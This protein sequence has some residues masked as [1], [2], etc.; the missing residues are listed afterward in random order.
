MGQPDLQLG[1]PKT[2]RVATIMAKWAKQTKACSV[3]DGHIL[4]F[5]DPI[6]FLFK[7]LWFLN[8]DYCCMLHDI[9]NFQRFGFIACT[10]R[11][12]KIYLMETPHTH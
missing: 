11:R 9:K 10:N 7:V 12:S 8:P 3:F 6:F 1:P 4:F 2:E 5:F